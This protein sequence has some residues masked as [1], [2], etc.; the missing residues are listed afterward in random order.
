MTARNERAT[1]KRHVR[2]TV[3]LFAMASFAVA[4][5]AAS[6][7]VLPARA[8]A[9]TPHATYSAS[10]DFCST[11]H[12]PHQAATD[13]G[14]LS[15]DEAGVPQVNETTLCYKCHAGTSSRT[16]VKNG[17]VN[18]FAG[19]SGHR[20]ETLAAEDPAADLTNTCTSCHSPHADW[21]L[22]PRLPKAD[23]NGVAVAGTGNPWC[24]ACH[25]DESDWYGPGY[26]DVSSP[27]R[28]ALG[29]P[30][31]GTFPGASVY[32]D[33]A[34]NAHA[35]IPASIVPDPMVPEGTPPEASWKASRVAG[36][37]LWCH[38]AHR[39]PSTYDGLVADYRSSVPDDLG[40]E[41]A[42][43]CFTCHAPGGQ[44][45]DI[46][47]LVA[48]RSDAGHSIATSGGI[49]EVGTAL[50][51]Y[52]CHGPHGS[53]RGNSSLISDTLGGGLDTSADAGVRAFCFSCHTSSDADSYGWDSETGTMTVEAGA[54]EVVGLARDGGEDAEKN[55]L[56]L[57]AG[58]YHSKDGATSCA[59]CHGSGSASVAVHDP[60][61]GYDPTKH[62]A[63]GP[64]V[65]P[66]CHATSVVTIHA[67]PGCDACHAD[68]ATPSLVC[69]NCHGGYAHTTADHTSSVTCDACHQVA[70]TD[71][72]TGSSTNL[73]GIHGDDC[74]L[75]HATLVRGSFVW[76]QTCEQE[77]CH[78]EPF[79]P[80]IDDHN[81]EHDGNGPNCWSCHDPEPELGDCVDCHAH[82]YDETPPTTTSDA[83]AGYVGNALI[84]LTA[85]D[86]P[87]SD[88]IPPG[89]WGVK[90]TYYQVDGGTLHTGT[91]IFVA[92]PGE[93]TE[94]H[95][96]EFW[97]LDNRGNTEAHK[98][99]TFT[100]SEGLPDA[101]PPF[102]TMSVN[103]DA[104]NTKS[105][106]ATINSSVSDAGSGM[107]QMQIDPGS[108]EYG[109]LIVYAPAQSFTL[110]GGDGIKT[111][112]VR[113]T[114]VAGNELVLT[115]TIRLDTVAPLTTSGVMG[116]MTYAG[117]QTF[118]LTPGDAGS[119]VASTRW[120]LDSTAG[121]WSSGTSVPVAAPSSGVAPHTLYWYSTDSAG[122]QEVTKS[123]S[124]SVQAP[125]GTYSTTLALT[126]WIWIDADPAA[127]GEWATY[128]IYANDVLIGTKSASSDSTW[129]CPQTLMPGGGHLDVVV[130]V[131]FTN[132][133]HI[134]DQYPSHTY[135][136]VLP[137]GTT[138]LDAA[139][140]T[141]FPNLGI[142]E[143]WWDDY[144]SE[145]RG[146]WVPNG[147]SVSNITYST[148]P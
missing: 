90:K 110:A 146:V 11:C 26:P 122:N 20:I 143:E 89:G 54:G 103:G 49:L 145:Y 37:C 28:D 123:V 144:G 53:A 74:G 39:S 47:S 106:A 38:S 71:P 14:L 109:S 81:I 6:G 9:A 131:G 68:G 142:T 34:R 77:G 147:V 63:G 129:A 16:N 117:A 128:R 17:L 66:G 132:P 32:S 86:P 137:A 55:A 21:E 62:V 83:V 125:P 120:Q 114:D 45:V 67:V 80:G 46:K 87:S 73:A 111:V 127:S 25:N 118:T 102:G 29:Y 97:S 105:T 24:L 64:C 44:A 33:P 96:I 30:I 1:T 115:D 121:T 57:P 19:S 3:L 124:F 119:G 136:L 27:T 51:C 13:R 134:F 23:V 141:G 85:Y 130:D 50:P 148:G 91:L 52:E 58:P 72:F 88:N 135:T 82:I 113:Y 61:G 116:G 93:G 2:E 84:T 107:A 8:L 101:T 56:K 75:C 95:T 78:A 60:T 35:S 126:E 5:I 10:T 133:I 70:S 92:A 112:S 36:D 138:Q 22:K 76:N 69:S 31:V 98:K 108:G 99:V 40:G 15:I 18:S 48:G 41:Y 104:P 12:R 140:W 94:S 79:H 42:A 4:A 7:A 43:M 65:T 59:D 100:V 139:V